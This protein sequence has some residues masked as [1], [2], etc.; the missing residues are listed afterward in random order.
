MAIARSNIGCS[1]TGNS[2]H[3]AY[4]LWGD[5]VAGGGGG[6][7]YSDFFPTRND[8]S[9]SNLDAS[10][11]GGLAS[12]LTR[13]PISLTFTSPGVKDVSILATGAWYASGITGTVFSINAQAA[14]VTLTSSSGT[15]YGGNGYIRIFR[16]T[17][18]GE[19]S[20]TLT[21]TYTNGAGGSTTTTVSLVATGY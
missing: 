12:S 6:F 1:S 4:N 13:N 9:L 18:S 3:I 8:I 11:M 20:G 15:R 2:G 16:N 7:N 10:S 17:N 14:V 5:L 21:I 19:Y